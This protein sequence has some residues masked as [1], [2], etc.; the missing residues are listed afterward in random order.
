MVQYNV[1]DGLDGSVLFLAE[2]RDFAMTV[3]KLLWGPSA[4]K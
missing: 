3:S 1:L 4:V 2:A